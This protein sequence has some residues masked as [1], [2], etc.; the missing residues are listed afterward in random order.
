MSEKLNGYSINTRKKGSYESNARCS[1]ISAPNNS[2][3]ATCSVYV[4]PFFYVHPRSRPRGNEKNLSCHSMITYKF[5][6]QW[7][8]IHSTA[9]S[10]GVSRLPNAL[11]VPTARIKWTLDRC[12]TQ[13]GRREVEDQRG[14]RRRV[15]RE[16]HAGERRPCD[17]ACLHFRMTM[18]GWSCDFSFSLW[19]ACFSYTHTRH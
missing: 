12:C 1:Y 7:N 14:V 4:Q 2:D 10:I 8:Y 17:L 18:R 5:W 6:V 3:V 19:R 9:F 11:S 13:I 15:T 16:F